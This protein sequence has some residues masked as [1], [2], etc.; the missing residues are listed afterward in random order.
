MK[1]IAEQMT[2][3]D[4]TEF[5]QNA[6]GDKY[7]HLWKTEHEVSISKKLRITFNL[8][9]LDKTKLNPNDIGKAVIEAYKAF[10][11]LAKRLT[12]VNPDV[13]V[14]LWCGRWN[15]SVP[16][17]SRLT[18]IASRCFK[19]NK[20][21]LNVPQLVAQCQEPLAAYVKALYNI[22]DEIDRLQLLAQQETKTLF[23]HLDG[24]GGI[25]L[26]TSTIDLP[27]IK[28]TT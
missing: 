15:K 23:E 7:K 13:Y 20:L 24:K 28:L 1:N 26:D 25:T 4:F 18:I 3:S 2:N 16:M 11:S 8:P 21:T 27:N 14:E 10:H 22:S 9:Q 6:F 17:P 19:L 12:Q 5:M